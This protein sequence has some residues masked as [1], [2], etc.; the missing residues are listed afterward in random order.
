MKPPLSYAQLIMDAMTERRV[1]KITLSEIYEYAA[2]RYAYYR[3][4][5]GPWKVR[6]VDTLLEVY[7]TT[8]I[9]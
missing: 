9:L 2:R 3:S 4:S 7:F 1:E 5:K 8:S 6:L